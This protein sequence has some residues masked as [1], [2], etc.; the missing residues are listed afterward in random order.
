MSGLPSLADRRGGRGVRA[1][2][3]PLS[4]TPLA[5]LFSGFEPPGDRVV[6]GPPGFQHG[7]PFLAVG[8]HARFFKEAVPVGLTGTDALLQIRHA[9]TAPE[10]GG[11]PVGGS[12]GKILRTQK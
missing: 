1:Q 9:R 5:G 3:R 12:D 2:L 6:V 11:A 4:G 8:P 7:T 10:R